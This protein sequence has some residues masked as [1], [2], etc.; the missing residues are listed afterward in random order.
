MDT[1]ERLALIE[2]VDHSS[3]EQAKRTLK[4]MILKCTVAQP[5][6]ARAIRAAIEQH[7]PTPKIVYEQPESEH[8]DES[9]PVSPR[10]RSK[11]E[12]KKKK[13]HDGSNQDE[14]DVSFA[15]SQDHQVAASSDMNAE[16]A[17]GQLVLKK[18]KTKAKSKGKTKPNGDQDGHQNTSEPLK[19][20]KKKHKHTSK[21]RSETEH[22]ASDNSMESTSKQKNPPV[23]DLVT[24]SDDE[25]CGVGQS[26]NKILEGKSS[27]S[28][29]SDNDSSKDDSSDN[30]DF[31]NEPQD[32]ALSE[33]VGP[34]Q[35]GSNK[36]VYQ[37]S[38]R[39]VDHRSGAVQSSTTARSKALDHNG[40]IEVS[41]PGLGK[42]RKAPERTVDDIHNDRAVKSATDDHFNKKSKQDHP[43]ELQRSL[44]DRKDLTCP[45]CNMKITSVAEI[46]KHHRYCNGAFTAL[47]G[48]HPSQSPSANHSRQLKQVQKASH[49]AANSSIDE[50]RNTPQPP[51]RPPQRAPADRG[52]SVPPKGFVHKP[53]NFPR[54][55]KPTPVALTRSILGIQTSPPGLVDRPVSKLSVD[56][57]PGHQSQLQKPD[58][59]R[60]RLIREREQVVH[61]CKHCKKSF[62]EY[63]NDFGA[64]K[65]HPGAYRPRIYNI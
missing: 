8:D 47:D 63:G 44:E 10:K 45:K 50:P 26:E 24:S 36:K 38:A 62:T 57:S 59:D 2:R 12:K 39:N 43:Q 5:T 3:G 55:P 46:L 56:G 37:A 18:K 54:G 4:F 60:E 19:K 42:K 51:S 58:S 52:L 22:H 15:T 23:I 1:N 31:E 48:H 9:A 14:E 41:F 20:K 7:A 35:D 40:G 33:G 32:D 16:P 49:P 21:R 65:F 27:S 34:I 13:K 29:G 64:C 30:E 6:I 61:Q 53:N 28:D 17:D 11:K 25:I